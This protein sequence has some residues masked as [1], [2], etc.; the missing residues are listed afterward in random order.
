MALGLAATVQAIPITGGISLS[1]GYVTDTGDLGTAHGF[2]SFSSVVVAAG[3]TDS[4]AGTGGNAVTMNLFTFDPVTTPVTTLWTFTVGLTTYSFDL[5]SMSVDHH[6]D[7]VLDISGSGMLHITDFDDTLGAWTF[8]ANSLG[9][10]FSFSSSN[11]AIPTPDGGVTAI[12]LGGALSALGLI[13]R[14]LA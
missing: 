14:K 4:Y 13:R 10:S 9:G 11:G 7:S 12:L 5:T 1:G 2:M 3:P 6:S 8:T